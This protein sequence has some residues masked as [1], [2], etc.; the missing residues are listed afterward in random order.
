MLDVIPRQDA[1]LDAGVD[2]RKYNGRFEA[3]PP[4]LDY[5]AACALLWLSPITAC[6]PAIV[7][8]QPSGCTRRRRANDS[9]SMAGQVKGASAKLVLRRL[10]IAGQRSQRGG[11]VVYN[12]GGTVQLLEVNLEQNS[13]SARPPFRSPT[14]AVRHRESLFAALAAG[15]TLLD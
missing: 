2:Q 5:P 12:S 14:G 11:A 7:I 3:R 13:V 15:L 4:A 8:C 6:C 1:L 9:A 10:H